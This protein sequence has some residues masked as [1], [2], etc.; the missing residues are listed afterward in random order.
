LAPAILAAVQAMVADGTYDAILEKHSVQTASLMD[1]PPADVA[2]L[3]VEPGINN[4]PM[5]A[6][7]RR[8]STSRREAIQ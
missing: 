4:S 6:R 5:T 1:C 8:H 7:V 2:P 3:C